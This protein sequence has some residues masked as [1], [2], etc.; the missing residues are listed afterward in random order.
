M[1]AACAG[2]EPATG[3]K[4]TGGGHG[5]TEN[6][7]LE[8]DRGSDFSRRRG[9]LR[10]RNVQSSGG[11]LSAGTALHARP[12]TKMACKAR[13]RP[14]HG[15][16]A[17]PGAGKAL[18]TRALTLYLVASLS[19][20]R[21]PSYPL[22]RGVLF[23]KSFHFPFPA[24]HGTL[25]MRR[26][27]CAI[28]DDYQNIALDVADWTKVA[29]DLEIKV[30]NEHLGGQESV[31]RALHDTEIVCAMRERTAFPRSMLERLPLLKLL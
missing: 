19:L 25:S 7:R 8:P 22:A 23:Y 29:A 11:S 13:S 31:I 27:R 2:P 6:C 15:P 16:G 5:E 18:I 17:D 28:L 1:G 9:G 10:T 3:E 14:R 24:S 21:A 20:S 12:R 30:F 4:S 26:Y